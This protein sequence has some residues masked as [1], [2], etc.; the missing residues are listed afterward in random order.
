MEYDDPLLNHLAFYLTTET[1]QILFLCSFGCRTMRTCRWTGVHLH[2]ELPQ[3][4]LDTRNRAGIELE[5]CEQTRWRIESVRREENKKQNVME[6][7]N[8]NRT[9][10]SFSSQSFVSSDSQS[11]CLSDISSTKDI[12]ASLESLIAYSKHT[13]RREWSCW[14]I[15]KA[16]HDRLEKMNKKYI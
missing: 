2:W 12:S 9:I 4:A 14:S 3:V 11:A 13:L 5:S 7:F 1:F 8:V 6:I 10:R 15:P 16:F